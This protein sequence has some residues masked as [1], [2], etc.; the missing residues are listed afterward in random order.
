MDPT[1]AIPASEGVPAAPEA[2][3]RSGISLAEALLSIADD[4]GRGLVKILVCLGIGAAV[5][6]LIVSIF[7]LAKPESWEYQ[8]IR[9]GAAP[10]GPILLASGVAI[11][12]AALLLIGFFHRGW[13]TSRHPAE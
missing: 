10:M 7:A 1:H 8:A 11:L 2:A 12:T 3:R 6:L 9:R 4:L 13:R 5:G